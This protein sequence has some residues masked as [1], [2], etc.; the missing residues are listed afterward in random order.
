MD[1]SI[2]VAISV[3]V[4]LVMILVFMAVKGQKE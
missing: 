2:I 3:P 1:Q 4:I